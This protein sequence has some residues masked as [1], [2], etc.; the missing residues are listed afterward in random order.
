MRAGWEKWSNSGNEM[1][2][3]WFVASIYIHLAEKIDGK[4]TRC[5][6]RNQRTLLE[7]CPNTEFSTSSVTKFFFSKGGGGHIRCGRNRS[8]WIFYLSLSREI[9]WKGDDNFHA[10]TLL[11]IF[12]RFSILP[13]GLLFYFCEF[14]IV[15]L[16]LIRWN[17]NR[18]REF[19][20]RN[21]DIQY[22]NT[23]K[24]DQF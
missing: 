16:R 23:Y 8:I 5:K 15:T 9:F 2:K 4:T 18:F 24:R 17:K 6:S 13:D 20:F 21:G 7:N 14:T 1:I 11:F 3:V 19:N 12:P 10:S 22:L